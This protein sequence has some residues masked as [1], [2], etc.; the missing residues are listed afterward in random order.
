LSFGALEFRQDMD[1]F[2]SIVESAPRAATR[3]VIQPRSPTMNRDTVFSPLSGRC[4]CEQVRFRIESAPII[5][6]CCHCSLCQR[7]SGAAFGMV[8]M[9]ETE[10]VALL[11]G[12]T[13]AYQGA[14]SH[15]QIQC[16]DCRCTLWV[17]R[18]DLGDA[19]ALV[20]VGMLDEGARLAP[21]AHYFTKSKQPWIA[22]PPGIPAFEEVGDPGKAGARER[23]MAAL[24]KAPT[25]SNQ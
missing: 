21:E 13:Q 11:A 25:L 24:A 18:P 6:H 16:P 19:L 10:H 7:S 22:L 15:K 1:F 12:R 8:A 14:R 20:R 2:W 3:R 5:T 9:I 17:H 23:I 4:R